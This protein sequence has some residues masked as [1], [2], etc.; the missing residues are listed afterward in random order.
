MNISMNDSCNNFAFKARFKVRPVNPETLKNAALSTA[1]VGSLAAGAAS[2][3]TV[4]SHPDYYSVDSALG[5]E[6]LASSFNKLTEAAPEGIPAQS[7]AIPGGLISSGANNLY[8][9]V[10]NSD[11]TYLPS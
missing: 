7:T 1:A 4:F 5:K 10:K 6:A 2:A 11:D 8:K 3:D 9:A